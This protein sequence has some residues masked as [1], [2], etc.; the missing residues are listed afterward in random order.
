MEAE[1]INELKG[2]VNRNAALTRRG[3]WVNLSFIFGIG[4][5]DYLINVAKGKIVEVRKRTLPTECG[6][7]SIRAT[8][9]TWQEHWQH[10][11]KR[12]YHDIW[13]MLPKKLITL[14]GNL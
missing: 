10:M 12:D 1:I 11:P 6:E 13:S 7:F 8:K 9:D 2:L 14:D 5:N 4:N 3:K